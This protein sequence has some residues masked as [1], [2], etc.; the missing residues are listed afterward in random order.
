MR[1]AVKS[2]GPSINDV[3][4]LGGGG[5]AKRWPYSL[6]LFSK[7]DDKGEGGVKNIKKWVTSFIDAP[8]SKLKIRI[9]IAYCLILIDKEPVLLIACFKGQSHLPLNNRRSLMD[10]WTFKKGMRILLALNLH[11]LVLLDHW[12]SPSTAF[13]LKLALQIRP[14]SCWY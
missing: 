5:S 8:W 7:M 9:L 4:H 10:D 3:T 13:A 11:P 1:T 12:S 6:S 2:N 14:S